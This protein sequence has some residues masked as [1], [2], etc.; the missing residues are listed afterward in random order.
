M[1]QALLEAL[2]IQQETKQTKTPVLMEFMFYH[3]KTGSTQI[4]LICQMARGSMEKNKAG[5]VVEISGG[6]VCNFQNVAVKVL[7]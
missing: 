1:Y 7:I 2:G 4:C 5:K 3:K 6:G